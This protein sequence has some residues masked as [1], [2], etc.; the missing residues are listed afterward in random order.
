[1]RGGGPTSFDTVLASRMGGLAVESLL[2]GESGKMV[3]S[4][5]GRMVLRPLEEAWG[6]RKPLNPELLALV[7]ILGV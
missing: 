1:Q 3:C 7:D 2:K 6:T 4:V 5:G